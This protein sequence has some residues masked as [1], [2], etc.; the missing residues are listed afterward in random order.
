[1]EKTKRY[2]LTVKVLAAI[3]GL[4]A[5]TMVYFIISSG[6]KVEFNINWNMFDSILM[7]P[8]FIVGFIVGLGQKFNVY[9]AV[10]RTEYSDGSVKI[11][12]NNDII[13]STM[14]GCI[15]PLL[16]YFVIFPLVVAAIIYYTLMVIVYLFGVI[17]PFVVS[18]FILLSVF[19]TYALLE[20]SVRS[21]RRNLLIPIIT[22]VAII[23]YWLCYVMWVW[24]YNDPKFPIAMYVTIGGSVIAL[25]SFIG[26]VFTIKADTELE[27]VLIDEEE[28]KSRL[29]RNLVITFIVFFVLVFGV[30]TFKM[31][32]SDS[33]NYSNN[34][35][36]AGT[37]YI[38]S[39]S[40]TLNIRS[41]PNKSSNIIGNLSNG[42]EVLVIDSNSEWATINYGSTI[43]YIS[44]SYLKIKEQN[45]S[46]E[47]EMSASQ[48]Q[49]LT[50]DTKISA[51]L[52][53]PVS[54]NSS[55]TI[56]IAK[57]TGM[58]NSFDIGYDKYY[59]AKRISQGD[60]NILKI[61]NVDRS[62]PNNEIVKGKEIYS[63]NNGKLATFLHVIHDHNTYEYLVS[64]DN[65]GNYISHI[66]IGILG[67]YSGDRGYGQ[68][69][70]NKI[71]IRNQIPGDDEVD[72]YISSIE[73]QIN[74]NLYFSKSREWKE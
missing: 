19:F 27:N 65:N 14:A 70:N 6:S 64:Y 52:S 48:T 49:N 12:K 7:W 41:A 10:I 28:P 38:V 40:S 58:I 31:C 68:I 50:T 25:G 46:T 33:Y 34:Y 39:T 44:K 69:T 53:E 54:S 71:I 55:Q 29:S 18:A 37:S 60:R 4:L 5:I 59:N 35:T 74:P 47:E 43:G 73:Y 26:L 1:M 56:T 72:G 66:C 3:A 21:K 32:S 13:E 2:Y 30:F 24:E 16:N 9:E 42:D 61:D 8:L 22:I 45:T 67:A 23:A 17:F 11:E 57:T 63:G 51:P 15:L 36:N 62:I 20:I